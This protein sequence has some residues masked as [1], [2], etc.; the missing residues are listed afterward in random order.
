MST[1]PAAARSR[2]CRCLRFWN[3]IWTCRLST[4]SSSA[5]CWRT[6]QAGKLSALKIVSSRA[7]PASDGVHLR[8][9]MP[10][11]P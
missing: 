3:Q 9:L 6:A 4:P 11:M 5:I 1:G 10:A 7:L 2:F 8:L